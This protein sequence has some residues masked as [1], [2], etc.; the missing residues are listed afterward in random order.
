[1]ATYTPS[2]KYSGGSTAHSAASRARCRLPGEGGGFGL[3]LA[4]RV[5]RCWC[6][7]TGLALTLTLACPLPL[8]CRE[9]GRG[10]AGLGWRCGEEKEEGL[11][12]ARACRAVPVPPDWSNPNR[13]YRAGRCWCRQTGLTLTGLT[14]RISVGV[15]RLV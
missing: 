10:R 8:A 4:Y 14:V 1:M 12:E 2:V 15:A 11:A 13:A 7:Q 9:A 3:G 6:R 5:D